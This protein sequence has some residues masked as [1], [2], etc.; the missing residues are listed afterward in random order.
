MERNFE[1]PLFINPPYF[2]FYEA[3][4]NFGFDFSP[5]EEDNFS[6]FITDTYLTD[7]II[8]RRNF[9]RRNYIEVKSKAHKLK[10]MGR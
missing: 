8:F 4:E 7:F 3:T 5:F 10:G 6:K 9:I 2:N 1:D